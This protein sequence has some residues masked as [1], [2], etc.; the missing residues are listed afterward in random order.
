MYREGVGGRLG[1][2]VEVV[3]RG[4]TGSY[5]RSDEARGSVRAEEEDEHEE[6]GSAVSWSVRTTICQREPPPAG[7]YCALCTQCAILL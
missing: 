5:P 7:P 4:D 1:G 2:V 3:Q 6:H